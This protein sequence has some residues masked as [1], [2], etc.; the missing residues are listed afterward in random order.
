MIIRFLFVA[1]A[2]IVT[3]APAIAQELA[4][5]RH[6]TFKREYARDIEGGHYLVGEDP[7]ISL[8][9]RET[10][11]IAAELQI[12]EPHRTKEFGTGVAFLFCDATKKR[13]V[14]VAFGDTSK[15]DKLAL[16]ALPMVDGDA[17]PKDLISK[18]FLSVSKKAN[19][20]ITFRTD[21]KGQLTIGVGGEVFTFDPGFDIYFLHVQIYCSKSRV[22]FLDGELIS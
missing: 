8:R 2:L 9:F 13:G 20:P 10:G 16:V 21:P 19:S 6:V 17:K 4:C 12:I 5:E 11:G 18:T 14:R 1:I 7:E 22:R 15:S 3:S